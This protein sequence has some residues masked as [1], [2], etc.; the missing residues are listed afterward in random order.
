MT[1]MLHHERE[2]EGNGQH[3]RPRR[4]SV[5][6]FT[7]A[8]VRAGVE[9][10]ILT[11]LRGLER[12]YFRLFLMCR[13]EVARKL[14]ADVPRDVEV[15]PLD[16][17]RLGPVVAAGRLARF[18]SDRHIDL[19]HSHQFSASLLA[20]PIGT[21]CRVPVIVETPHLREAW[22]KGWLK[23]S[24]VLDRL[25]GHCVDYYI[26]VSEANARYLVDEKGLPSRKVVVIH[27]GIDL[28][29]FD[30]N[31]MA[32]LAMRTDMGFADDDPVLVVLARLEPQ[33]GHL[34]LLEALPIVLREF[35][36]VRLVCVGEG[37]QRSEIEQQ[38]RASGLQ[39]SV[40]F[41]GYQS[42]PADWLALA[43]FTVLPSHF[44]GLPIA[45]I[46]SLAM[47]KTMVATRVDGTPE[48]VVDGKTGLT[49]PPG[50]PAALAEAIC[51]L[52]GDP[53]LRQRLGQAGR[54]WARLG[55]SQEEQVRKTGEL[56][57]HALGY[58]A[59][60]VESQK[61]LPPTGEACT[62]TGQAASDSQRASRR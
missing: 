19:L 6:H 17:G 25:V 49:V 8:E 27:N 40:R 22:R 13:P 18:L 14:G 61:T 5:A 35:P 21:L 30:P 43:A 60:T 10:H 45:A 31:H 58:R 54:D 34:N 15:E 51:R 33:K 23:G 4:A 37:A 2:G 62:C 29:R 56:Y 55:F 3:Q 53:D 44:E 42:N 48:V 52:L 41:V 12:R 9:E 38:A 46:E 47:G 11:L 36:R 26:A 32:P 28:S 16:L 50:K 24:F 1:Q 57:L 39:E 20:S 59:E 7:A